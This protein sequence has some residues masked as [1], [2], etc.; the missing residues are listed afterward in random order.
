[1]RA[2]ILTLGRLQR[3]RVWE[4]LIWS[5]SAEKAILFKDTNL[6]FP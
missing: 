5:E 3:G 6:C 1:M 2:K 4:F